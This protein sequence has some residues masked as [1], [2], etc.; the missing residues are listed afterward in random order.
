MAVCLVV[1]G[2]LAAA[3]VFDWGVADFDLSFGESLVSRATPAGKTIFRAVTVLG[4]TYFVAPFSV[5]VGLVFILKKQWQRAVIF[6]L[7]ISGS[8]LLNGLLKLFFARLR[9]AYPQAPHT[10]TSFSFPS[11]HAMIAVLM[12]GI[13]VYLLMPL[14]K[15]KAARAVL[16]VGAIV[17]TLLVGFSRL[18]LGVHYLSDVLAGFAF[19]SFLLLLLLNADQTEFFG[20]TPIHK[21]Y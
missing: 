10:M 9:P 16:L 19:S 7:A 14:I 17:L 11:G 3:Y 18:Y 13:L 8:M 5:F 21:L 2:L 20:K 15:Q 1:F 6:A 4:N 12:F